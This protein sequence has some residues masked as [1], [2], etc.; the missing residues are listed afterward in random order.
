MRAKV[1]SWEGAESLEARGGALGSGMERGGAWGGGEAPNVG[2]AQSAA[3][4]VSEGGWIL[5]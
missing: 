3:W 4:W 2:G 5:F 1:L